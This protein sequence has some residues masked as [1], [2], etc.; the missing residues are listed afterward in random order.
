MELGPPFPLSGIVECVFSI[1]VRVSALPLI[2]CAVSLLDIFL[3]PEICTE[4][5]VLGDNT[6]ALP[7]LPLKL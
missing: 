2:G 7:R 4:I 3:V 6:P 1:L 5:L